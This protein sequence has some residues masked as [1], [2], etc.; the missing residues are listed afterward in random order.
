LGLICLKNRCVITK[1][2]TRGRVRDDPLTKVKGR[3]HYFSMQVVMNKCFLP[4]PEKNWWRD[5]SCRFREKCK[6]TYL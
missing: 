4:N 5:P 3:V 6:K 2:H 1:E